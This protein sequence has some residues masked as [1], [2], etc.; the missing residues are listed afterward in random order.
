[1]SRLRPA[2]LSF[3][4][5]LAGLSGCSAA[6]PPLVAAPGAV[7][8][9]E[10]FTSEG[11][12]SCPPA[13]ALLNR[14]HAQSQTPDGPPVIALAFHVDYWDRLGWTDPYGSRDHSLR[15]Q[16]YSETLEGSTFTAGRVYTPQMV[17]NGT[18]G[19]VGSASGKA[20]AALTQALAAPAAVQVQ[21]AAVRDGDAVRLD[22][23]LT[24]DRPL[25]GTTQVNLVLAED[26][27]VSA[28][29]RGENGGRTLEHDAV[30]RSFEAVPASGGSGTLEL[31][32]PPDVDAAN[33]SA[34]AYVQAKPGGP[35]LGG[36]RVVPG[37]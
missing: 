13:E 36:T 4:L 32:L 37:S 14:L 35:I 11:C 7:A 20:H 21:L 3:L 16:V 30:V 26:R 23:S 18:Q 8:V 31:A 27:I 6:D 28:I 17:V 1:M 10:L 12:S 34:V 33:L 19:F 22:W 5:S 9:V 15:Q 24:S 25:K 2:A 29:G